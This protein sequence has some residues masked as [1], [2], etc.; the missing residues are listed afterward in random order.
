VFG[1]V[2]AILMHAESLIDKTERSVIA[3]DPPP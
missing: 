1:V 2:E 3:D